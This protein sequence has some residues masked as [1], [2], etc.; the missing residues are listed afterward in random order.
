[1]DTGDIVLSNAANDGEELVV[2]PYEI[3]PDLGSVPP[4]EPAGNAGGE[5]S[6]TTPDP[7][8]DA[9]GETGADNRFQPDLHSEDSGEEADSEATARYGSII[10]DLPD[11]PLDDLVHDEQTYRSALN[12]MALKNS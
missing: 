4:A 3:F 1:M 8:L 7:A 2:D 9:G 6:M 10:D 11:P 12:Q 5:R